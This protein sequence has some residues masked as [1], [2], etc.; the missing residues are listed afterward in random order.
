MKKLLLASAIVVLTCAP[1][2]ANTLK[3]VTDW[4]EKEQLPL[5]VGDIRSCTEAQDWVMNPPQP[6]SKAFAQWE[7]KKAKLLKQCAKD[8]E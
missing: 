1:V 3:E 5:Q 7:K 4:A 6:F 2:H 8:T